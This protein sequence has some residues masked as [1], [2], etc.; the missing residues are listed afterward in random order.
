MHCKFCSAFRHFYCCSLLLLSHT[1]IVAKCVGEGEAFA[2][3]G[4]LGHMKFS[5]TH[6]KCI[7]YLPSSVPLIDEK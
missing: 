6:W 7:E 2:S 5:G 3:G 1:L 4:T